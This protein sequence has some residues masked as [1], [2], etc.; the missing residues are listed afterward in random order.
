MPG[1]KDAQREQQRQ[2]HCGRREADQP[3]G[4]DERGPLR[5]IRALEHNRLRAEGRLGC[6]LV[7]HGVGAGVVSAVRL[8]G[9]GRAADEKRGTW[10]HGAGAVGVSV[11]ALRIGEARVSVCSAVG[12]HGSED[13]GARLVE[14]GHARRALRERHA[15]PV[16]EDGHRLRA[17]T[18]GDAHHHAHWRRL[19]ASTCALRA[20]F[21]KHGTACA[22][23]PSRWRRSSRRGSDDCVESL[24]VKR[25]LLALLDRIAKREERE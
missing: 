21:L 18:L 13:L 11:L 8:G 9:D 23:L 10:E 16:L 25:Q 7:A 5:Y 6:P 2:T 14:V 24:G 20:A 12:A 15:P 4:A 19:V 17:L 1:K 22:L 3:L